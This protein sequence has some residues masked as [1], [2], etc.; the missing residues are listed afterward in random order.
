MK[1]WNTGIRH[2]EHP[3][4]GRLS[5]EHNAFQIADRKYSDLKLITCVPLPET[6][7]LAKIKANY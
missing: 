6:D 2:F 7:T 3:Q 5:F 4:L 1:N